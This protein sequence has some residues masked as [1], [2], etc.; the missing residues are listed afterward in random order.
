M[1]PAA[2]GVTLIE[3]LVALA[4]LGISLAGIL[5]SFVTQLHSNTRNEERSGAVIAAQWV[6]D[7]LR[8]QDPS[9]LPATGASAPQL[10]TIGASPYEVTTRYCQRTAFCGVNSRHLRIEVRLRNREL[11]DVETVYTRLR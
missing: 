7:S 11:Y 9:T 3:T 10:V 5:P 1:S 6:L 2:R 4:I 8:L